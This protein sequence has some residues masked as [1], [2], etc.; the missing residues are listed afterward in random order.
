MS[1]PTTSKKTRWEKSDSVNLKSNT[2]ET[3]KN[4]LLQRKLPI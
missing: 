2:M 1:A 4:Y 3:K